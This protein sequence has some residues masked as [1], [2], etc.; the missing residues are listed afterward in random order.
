VPAP[1]VPVKAVTKLS[2]IR[3]DGG[4]VLSSLVI[5]YVEKKSPF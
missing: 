3:N 1:G 5:P 2:S 4:E